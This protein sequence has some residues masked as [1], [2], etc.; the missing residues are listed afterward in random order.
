VT[1]ATLALDLGC[2]SCG[3]SLRVEAHHRTT[4]CPYC[5]ATTIVERPP[6]TD[7]PDPTFV[8][9]FQLDGAQAARRVR[10][11]IGRAGLLAPSRFKAAAVAKTRAVYVPA[12]LYGAAAHATFAADIGEDYQVQVEYTTKDSSGRTVRRTRTETR[13]EWRDLSGR[14]ASWIVDVIVTASRGLTNVDLARIEPFQLDA[15]ARYQPTLLAG[16]LAEEPSIPRDNC[17]EMARAEAQAAAGPRLARF[18]PGDRHRNLR[19]EVRFEEES[20]DLVMLP[21]WTFAARWHEDKPP[22]RILVNGQ[23][24]EVAG[25]VPRSPRKIALVVLAV[26]ALV[27]VVILGLVGM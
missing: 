3:A 23:T 14:H 4:I 10:Q 27:A 24:G 1:E 18:L 20:A 16:W 7:R 25:D 17:L 21:V 26:L 9:G 5:D 22:V 2:T 12:Y 19:H 13:T 15:I 8:I 11:W 6:T